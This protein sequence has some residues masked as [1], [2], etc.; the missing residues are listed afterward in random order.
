LLRIGISEPKQGFDG[1]FLFGR[2]LGHIDRFFK[3]AGSQYEKQE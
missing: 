3:L 2:E 1:V